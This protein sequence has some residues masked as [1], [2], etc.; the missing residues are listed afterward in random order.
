M[1]IVEGVS[2]NPGGVTGAAQLQLLQHRLPRLRPWPGIGISPAGY[3]PDGSQGEGRATETPSRRVRVA[4]ACLQTASASP[5]RT[6][7]TKRRSSGFTTCR[8]RARCSDSRP[9]GTTVFRSGRGTASASPF[10]RIATAT[11]PSSGSPPTAAPRNVSPGRIRANRMRPSPG[12]RRATHFL[13]SVTKGS[14]VSLWTFSLQDRKATLFGAV[15]SSNPTNAVFSPDGNWVAYASTERGI[16]DDL[17][18][19]IPSH[20]RRGISSSRK[21]PTSP[22][23]PRWSPDGKELFYDAEDHWIRSRERHDA[24]DVCVRECRGGAEAVPHGRCKHFRTPYDITPDG[25]LVGRITAGQMEY[26][27]SSVDQIQVVLNWFEELKK[28]T[29]TGFTLA[30]TR[31][32]AVGP[33]ALSADQDDPPCRS[34]SASRSD[35]PTHHR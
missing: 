25:K 30:L 12:L 17:R 2:R 23:H 13:F 35:Q 27:R 20:W 34:L 29:V 32:S 7:T 9:E 11:S 22:H 21:G 26:V 8:A 31:V 16:D 19:A 5:S 14:D 6:M 3:W 10:S 24:T 4:H 18:A 28:V 1:Q 33:T 15:H